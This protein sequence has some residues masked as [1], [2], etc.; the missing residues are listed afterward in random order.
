MQLAQFGRKIEA[1]YGCYQ[2]IEWAFDHDTGE[3]Y[4][5]QARP[6]TTLK[7]EKKTVAKE[8][9]SNPTVLVRG[10]PASPGIG[11]GSSEKHKR[12]H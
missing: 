2:D 9:P 7:E 4:I 8:A 5:L 10:L 11:S 1:H 12:Y 6:I 3:L